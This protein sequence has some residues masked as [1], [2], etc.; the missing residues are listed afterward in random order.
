MMNSRGRPRVVVLVA[1]NLPKASFQKTYR[2]DCIDGIA[3]GEIN[4]RK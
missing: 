2:V 3:R 1:V 4:K